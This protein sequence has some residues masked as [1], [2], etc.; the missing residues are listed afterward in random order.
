MACAATVL[1]PRHPRAAAQTQ[2]ITFTEHV[3]PI[4]FESCATCHRPAGV[5]PF[6]LLTYDEVKSR[7]GQIADV[8]RRRIM[9][10]WK[11]EPGHGEFIGERRL[12]DAQIEVLQAWAAGGAIEGDPARMPPSPAWNGEWQLGEPDL[13]L[14]TA[15]YTLP[16][17]GADV[18]RNFVLPIS[19]P[20][21]R[22]IKAWQF[23]PGSSHAVHHATMQFDRAGAS[24]RLDEKDGEPGYEGLIPHT[25]QSPDGYFLGWTPGQLAYVAPDGMAWALQP[26]TDVVMMLHLRPHEKQEQVRAK[27][28]LYVSDAPPS[29]TPSMIRLTRQD[30]DIPA[31][32]GSYRVS[33]SFR[34]NV[35]VD[36][37][38]VQPHAHY[39][40]REIRAVATLP[41]GTT[42]PLIYI[43]DWDFNW[44]D[45]FRY[46]DPIF[47]PAGT[48]IAMAYVYDNSGQN[49]R[50]PHDPPR[51]VTYGQQTTDEMAELWLQVVARNAADR[52]ALERA[53]NSKIVREEIVGREKMLE[54]DWTS[55]SLHDDVAM[56][57]VAIG[58]L[59]QAARHFAETVRLAPRSPAAHYNYGNVLLARGELEE[60]AGHFTTALTLQ[61]DYALAHGGLGRAR[62]AEGRIEAAIEAFSEA[63]RLDP[64]DADA[65]HQLAAVLRE[66]GRLAEALAH[67]RQAVEI[68]PANAAARKELGELER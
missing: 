44:Q 36:A 49:P 60:A 4:V 41:D 31:G 20:E 68:D 61:P 28:G 15:P 17:G 58:A 35:D 5:A 33:D 43:S 29:R 46:R 51:R 11:P 22:Y 19:I 27:I 21:T 6:S 47:L 3:A 50:N 55:T 25:V 62:R 37:Y 13:V 65:H 56:L 59:D 14:E 66:Q 67:Y 18:Y 2:P 9:P 34:L 1:H 26:R 63:V 40:A 53:A 57:Y 45:V 52:P 48:T 39:L 10:P 12:T 64:G 42:T 38:A 23:L 24:R 8:T 54:S 30:L 7:A 32:V 16:A